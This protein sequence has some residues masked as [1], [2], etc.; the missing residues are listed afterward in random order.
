MKMAA[1]LVSVHGTGVEIFLLHVTANCNALTFL[2]VH[3]L[4]NSELTNKDALR[5][6]VLMSSDIFCKDKCDIKIFF[7][8][9][10]TRTHFNCDKIL[11]F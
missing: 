4:M 6:N 11:S 1:R 8:I 10:F 7:C 9:R 5:R 3:L 2:R